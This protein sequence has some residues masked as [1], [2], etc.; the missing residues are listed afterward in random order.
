MDFILKN[1][2]VLDSIYPVPYTIF[3]C[4]ICISCLLLRKR[5]F[6]LDVRALDKILCEAEFIMLFLFSIVRTDISVVY[7]LFCA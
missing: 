3:L 1:L 7:F 5:D 6:P 4:L 2:S